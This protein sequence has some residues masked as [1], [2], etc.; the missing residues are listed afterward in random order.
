[1]NVRTAGGICLATLLLAVVGPCQAAPAATQG[2][3]IVIGE[4]FQL[5]SQAIGEERSYFVHRPADYELS[6]RRYP[7]VIVLDGEDDFQHVSTTADRLADAGAI[8]GLLVVGIPNTQRNRDLVPMTP[9]SGSDRF[10]KFITTEL[11]PKLDQDLRTQTYRILVGHSNGGLLGVYSLTQAP[12]VFRGYILASPAFNA[13]DQPLLKSVG[14]FLENHKDAAASIYLTLANESDLLS[15]NEELSSYLQNASSAN[16]NFSFRFRRYPEET[17]GTVPLR[18][19]YDGLEFI[20][21][22]WSI[23]DPFA[24][25]EQGGLAAIEKHYAS[26]ASRLGFPVAVP[27]DV[28]LAP[29]FALYRQKR[30]DEAEKVIL[31]TLELY[32][33]STAA[34]LTAGRL[35]FDKGEKPKARDYLTQALLLS[36]TARAGGVDYAA[37]NLDPEKVVPTANVSA[38]ALRKCVGNYGSSVPALRIVQQ[39]GALVAVVADRM[40]ELTALSATRFYFND[41]EGVIDF[42]LGRGGHVVG[43]RLESRGV[44]LARLK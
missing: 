7:L 17:H 30:T 27:G 44:E 40:K 19:V 18:S 1:M 41:G 11:I 38:R 10:L 28:L 39:G 43:L 12:G 32:P 25:Y 33:E 5:H 24:L 13:S 20:F 31:R 35:Y 14:A 23:P 36:P 8:P 37:L 34:L 9:Q 3:P 6:D 42:R 22:G 29:A 21:D 4:R 15:G 16:V 26:L 2:D